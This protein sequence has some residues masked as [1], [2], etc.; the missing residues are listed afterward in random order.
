M[1]VTGRFKTAAGQHSHK[2]TQCQHKVNTKFALSLGRE[3][4]GTCSAKEGRLT[5]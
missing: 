5:P 3:E 2:G 4:G 1:T